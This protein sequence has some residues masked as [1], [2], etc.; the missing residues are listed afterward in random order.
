MHRLFILLMHTSLSC[1]ES[2]L[3]EKL[4]KEMKIIAL[5][6]YGRRERGICTIHPRLPDADA[7]LHLKL[8]TPADVMATS[9][10]TSCFRRVVQGFEI[11]SGFEGSRMLGSD[12]NDE[13]YM[14]DGE[15]RTR[16]N[17]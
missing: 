13:F 11:G 14:A 10:R 12:H 16:T 4:L 3:P 6:I 2:Q 8:C 15:V 17:R 1:H 9:M 7:W 5:G